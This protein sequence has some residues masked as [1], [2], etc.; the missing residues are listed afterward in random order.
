MSQDAQQ[1]GLPR[2]LPHRR[3]RPRRA[4]GRRQHVAVGVR[5]RQPARRRRAPPAEPPTSAPSTTSSPGS[6]TSSSP[7]S[8]SPT[9]NGY[10]TDDGFSERELHGRRPDRPAGRRRGLGQGPARHRLARHHR[11]RHP[12]GCA[13]QDH[14]GALPEEPLLR[15]VAGRATRSPRPQDMYG[16]SI[17]V[18][19]VNE[20]V[21][22]SFLQGQQPRR[23]P[24]REG[25]G[26]VR[27]AAARGRR[28]RRLVLVR[29]QRAEP[30]QGP[31]RRD[32]QLPA[33]RLQ[34]PA[35]LPDLHGAPRTASRTSRDA[36]K[37]VLKADIMGW[38]RVDQGPRPRRRRYAV[39]NYGKDLGLDRRRSRRSSPRPR[40]SSS[41]QPDTEANGIMTIT[42]TLLEETIA[43]LALGGTRSRRSS[44]ST[45][46]C[47]TRSTRRTPTS[48]PPPSSWSPDRW[49]PC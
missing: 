31:G 30:A 47:S 35:R 32:R 15:D 1:A 36:L 28:G 38:Q 24:D 39:E 23:P 40:T 33:Q 46:R 19:A 10:Y 44:C 18:Q 37:A 4:R 48:R 27:P 45:C 22:N 26:P 9:P 2:P 41:S 43:T 6:R 8:T 16:K 5:L 7:V 11:P 12:Q 3:C 14:R 34:L 20:P 17:G 29:H 25:P 13:A 21:W 49:R 42:D